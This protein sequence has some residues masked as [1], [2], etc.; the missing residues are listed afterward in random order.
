MKK[1]IVLAPTLLLLVLALASC[2]QSAERLNNDGNEAFANQDY[3]GSLVAYQ[4]AA[5]ESPE[6]AEPHYNAANSHYRLEDYEQAQQEIEQALL[7]EESQP[8]LDQNSLYNLGNTFF[9]TE[10][11]EM[12]IEV[13]KEALRLKPDDLEAKQN[14]ELALRKLQ[15]QQQEQQDQQDQ[16]QQDQE[17]QDQQDQQNQDQQDQQNQDQQDQQ[18]QDQQDQQNQDQQDQ[19]NQDQQQTSNRMVSRRIR[20]RRNRPATS[21]SR[22]LA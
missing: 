18:N 22:S 2:G 5:G 17:N 16:E 19:Q 12:A 20:S 10:Q 4:Q 7:G 11:Y 6:L 9:Q 21:L 13:Y 8:D 14:L 3:T 1:L 15:E